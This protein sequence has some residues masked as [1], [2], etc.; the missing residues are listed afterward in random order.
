MGL[1]FG[2]RPEAGKREAQAMWLNGVKGM[3]LEVDGVGMDCARFGSGSKAL[4]LVPG[5]SL[6]DV[7]GA[8][9]P[10]AY[11]YRCFAKEHTVYILD[12]RSV[13]PEGYT[14]RDLAD[15]AARAMEQL[16][17]SNA[18]VFGVSQGGMIAQYLAIDHPQ[19]VHKLVLSV[20]ASRSNRVMEE[21]VRGWVKM[22]ESG[23]YEALVMDIFERMYSE[24]YLKRYHLLFPILT[25]LGRP[26]NPARFI[27]LAKACLTCNAYPELHKITCPTLVIGGEQDHVLTG[28]ASREI[29]AAL[30]CELYMYEDLGH[31]AYEEAPDHNQRIVQFL[32]R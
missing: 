9:L 29:A 3:T 23:R 31:S 19:L 18:D 22:V 2:S 21:A 10:L 6:R 27:A 12:K 4:V 26:K 17:L 28:E 13:V 16:G 24:D 1:G 8:E 14:I 30:Q 5:L 32:E 11:L 25:R 7:K 15:D 20:T